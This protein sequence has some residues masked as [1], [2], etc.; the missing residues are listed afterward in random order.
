[1]AIHGESGKTLPTQTASDHRKAESER[2]P[3]THAPAHLAATESPDELIPCQ[4]CGALVKRAK[5]RLHF[6]NVHE[7]GRHTPRVRPGPPERPGGSVVG[8]EAPRDRTASP[9]CDTEPELDETGQ[10]VLPDRATER[11][12]DATRDYYQFREQGRFGSH[13]GH[14]GF[15]DDSDP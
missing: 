7:E 5:M 2:R 15:G 9:P 14:D 12:Q 10:A 8:T 1:M 11:Q 3:L 6:V 13:P 4:K